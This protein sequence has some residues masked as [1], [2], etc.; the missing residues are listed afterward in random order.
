MSAGYCRQ[1]QVQPAEHHDGICSEHARGEAC[2]CD[3]GAATVICAA[4]CHL[5]STGV[6]VSPKPP[7]WPLPAMVLGNPWATW[8]IL[9][10]MTVRC[11][12]SAG[13]GSSRCARGRAAARQR[14]GSRQQAQWRARLRLQAVHDAA[15]GAGQP[16]AGRFRADAVPGA[17]KR[18]HE[19]QKRFRW[20]QC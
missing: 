4:R 18:V 1:Q 19:V 7:P 11:P 20:P 16:G 14:R 8:S 9:R 12:L 6:A 13:A 2:R 15:G 5:R 17:R 3:G 10:D